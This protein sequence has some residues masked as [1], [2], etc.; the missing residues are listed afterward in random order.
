MCCSNLQNSYQQ[1]YIAA[2]NGGNVAESKEDYRNSSQQSQSQMKHHFG[3]PL[4]LPIRNQSKYQ[5]NPNLS[6]NGNSHQHQH[7]HQHLNQ[8]QMQTTSPNK[9]HVNIFC[10]NSNS[11]NN[12][13]SSSPSSKSPRSRSPPPP[14]ASASGPQASSSQQQPITVPISSPV[15]HK[16]NFIRVNKSPNSE[17]NIN[18]ST[19]NNNNIK[20]SINS[21]ST[22]SYNYQQQQQPRESELPLANNKKINYCYSMYSN[23]NCSIR[24]SKPSLSGKPSTD[25]AQPDSRSRRHHSVNFRLF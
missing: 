5:S 15:N 1:P 18:T 14:S 13:S 19:N 8:S 25:D 21:S 22:S 17:L 11:N 7:Q 2:S 10:N 23:Y 3:P 4:Q 9:T 16:I 20:S 6:M 24:R 12:S